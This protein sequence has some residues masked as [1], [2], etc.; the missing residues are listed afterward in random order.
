M[1]W[2]CDGNTMGMRWECDGNSHK[3]HS[4]PLSEGAT[5]T[6][7]RKR[8]SNFVVLSSF[9]KKN[10][11]NSGKSC[12]FAGDITLIQW[13]YYINTIMIA[14]SSE[15]SYAKIGR[16]CWFVAMWI[17]LAMALPMHAQTTYT[18]QNSLGKSR[19]PL[20]DAPYGPYKMQAVH[21]DRVVIYRKP[22]R[23]PFMLWR[24]DQAF[25]MYTRW[26]DYSTNETLSGLG[27]YNSGQQAQSGLVQT[28]NNGVIWYEPNKYGSQYQ[29]DAMYT[30]NPGPKDNQVVY[31][32]CDQSSYTDWVVDN[33][34]NTFTEPTL[35]Q[36][37]VFEI[38]PA[39][40]MADKVDACSGD[41]WLE[42]Y[43]IM[44][45]TNQRVYLGPKY[46]FQSSERAYPGYFYTD[47]KGNIQELGNKSFSTSTGSSSIGDWRKTS[48][49]ENRSTRYICDSSYTVN[50][51]TWTPKADDFK[52][53]TSSTSQ[54]ITGNVNIG[55]L[56]WNFSRR[57]YISPYIQQ[58]QSTFTDPI[59]D[60]QNGNDLL[61]GDPGDNSNWWGGWHAETLE[62][63]A[64]FPGVID[65]VYITCYAK[66]GS[67]TGTNTHTLKVNNGVTIWDPVAQTNGSE[68]LL[69]NTA[70]TYYNK[71]NSI[72]SN[73]LTITFTAK[74]LDCGFYIQS[75]QVHYKDTHTKG[76][77]IT[78]DPNPLDAQFWTKEE[79]VT[80]EAN[81]E[82]T[83]KLT[84]GGAGWMWFNNG[85]QV[86]EPSVSSGQFI[87]ADSVSS[88]S[89]KT[90]QL[91]YST[92][93]KTITTT[94][95]KEETTTT[96]T[97]FRYNGGNWEEVDTPHV[98]SV[99]T[100]ESTPTTN[101]SGT[102][103][104]YKIAQFRVKYLNKDIV[105]P[106]S[107]KMN[108]FISKMELLVEQDFNFEYGE[109]NQFPDD[110]TRYY[111]TPLPIEQSNYGFYYGSSSNTDRSTNNSSFRNCYYNEYQFVN[112][113][114]GW[115]T[116][117]HLANHVGNDT[118]YNKRT[119]FALYTDGSQKPGTVFSIDF[120]AD[121]CPGAKMYFSAW[122]GDQNEGSYSAG[123]PIFNFYVEGIDA[124]GNSHTLATFTTGEFLKAEN[125]WHYILFPLEFSEETI[126]EKYRFRIENMAATTLNND[127]FLDDV[128]VYLQRAS[129]TP[130]QASVTSDASCLNKEGTM[131]LCTRVD[132]GSGLVELEQN[133]NQYSFYYRWY[134]KNGNPVDCNYLNKASIN[135]LPYGKVSFPM[136]ITTI[137][138]NDTVISF[139]RFDKVASASTNPLFKF[140]EEEFLN[141]DDDDLST[142]K[143]YVLYVATPIDV[144]LG[145]FYR[146]IVANSVS[147]LPIRPDII[148]GLEK[149]SSDAIVQ[150]IHGLCIRCER[151]GGLVVD[152]AQ[153]NANIS[154][155][156]SLVSETISHNEGISNKNV[157]C[158][159]GY[160]LFGRDTLPGEYDAK[161]KIN[162][163]ETLYGATY[164]EVEKAII[165]YIQNVTFDDNDPN[166]S[167]SAEQKALVERLSSIGVLKLS[168]KSLVSDTSF[169]VLPLYT[170]D[171]I[172][173]SVFP[174]CNLGGSITKCH[175]PL[176]ISL[177]FQQQS[178][179]EGGGGGT[180]F[181]RNAIN[182]VKKSNE[183]LPKF[184][185]N[186][187]ARRV[188]IS[189]GS[190]DKLVQIE[191][192]DNHSRYT[193]EQAVMIETTNTNL[194]STILNRSNWV[195]KPNSVITGDGIKQ[196]K[197]ITLNDLDPGYNYTFRMDYKISDGD[198][199]Y[200]GEAFIT[201]L[202][203]PEVVYY[204]GTYTDAW[205][206]DS[207]WQR[208]IGN[209]N[210]VAALA[211]LHNTKVVVKGDGFKLVVKPTTALDSAVQEQAVEANAQPYITYDI[212]YEPFV[213]SEVFLYGGFHAVLGQHYLHTYNENGDTIPPKWTFE[214]WPP[215]KDKW[216]LCSMPIK[217]VVFGDLF[218]PAGREDGDDV[219]AVR[220][221][222][223]T[224][225]TAAI[226]RTTLRFYNSLYN[227]E[228]KQYLGNGA[229]RDITTST[230]TYGT[231]ILD[232]VIRAGFGWALGKTYDA[233]SNQD[234]L[235]RLPKKDAVYHYYQDGIWVDE[236]V[237]INRSEELG[238][239]MYEL[240]KDGKMVIRL[241]NKTPSKVF[242]FGNPTFASIDME[243][244]KAGNSHIKGFIRYTLN[245]DTRFLLAS[246]GSSD[247]WYSNIISMLTSNGVIP[248]E[249]A[250]FIVL[251]ED[252]TTVDVTIDP[253][254]L[255]NSNTTENNQW[256][257]GYGEPWVANSS[258]GMPAS[259]ETAV[260]PS[261][262]YITA[263]VGDFASATSII[264]A[265]DADLELFMLD[266][267][268]TP[269]A[270]YTVGD[271]KA[272]AINHLHDGQ[273]RIPLAMYAEEAVTQPL[274]T[275]D[276]EP[277]D[278]AEWDLVDTQTGIRQPLYR[279]LTMHLNMPQ[280][281][282]VRYYL[283]R[284]RHG[285]YTSES[286]S[287]AF[288]TYA[289]G[290]MLTIYSS[291][292]LY[293]LCVYDPAGRLLYQSAD[294]GTSC[295]V[296]L[297]AGTYIVRASGSTLKVIV[298]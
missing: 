21:E 240:D 112:D 258:S 232:T 19:R 43:D 26:Y 162:E 68:L 252:A 71:E 130:I 117:N 135:G 99:I 263:T 66:K 266:R 249:E 188:R 213:C 120:G 210:F 185:H 197:F 155:E 84:S 159:Y 94:Y 278:I 216:K 248:T 166:T 18:Y 295:T 184:M 9:F 292:T 224:P 291:D 212:G 294:A 177:Y 168:N 271:G 89:T 136:D 260:K 88:P 237:P 209:N 264:D 87:Y 236:A 203:V 83:D 100:N 243:K 169:L 283:E 81:Y 201:F 5:V 174:L 44:A 1:R 289:F 48:S 25:L 226:D 23:N 38:H 65:S 290:G 219:F 91:V 69:S 33:N 160:W 257:N 165:A 286:K 198:T 244:M 30:Y 234:T 187:Q 52:N 146:C 137:T 279:G 85:T 293:D 56:I 29:A 13:Q 110:N 113:G 116:N 142:E 79:T 255:R 194:N 158:Y 128:R 6:I 3:V 12:N 90:Y 148:T 150:V 239:P 163:L 93:S 17:V 32:G 179:P 173:Y 126:Y 164:Q 229:Y 107:K 218:I 207:M 131:M 74:T 228:T 108:D 288:Q 253:S 156:L 227:H 42:E 172:H 204:N 206:D 144:E 115:K 22:S 175:S 20:V 217:G 49:T 35:S 63:N 270:I 105:G 274:F 285:I 152:E 34:S 97:K 41:K 214:F 275:F 284:S 123:R 265:P 215:D 235:M 202:V 134:D 51:Y 8:R 92:G 191:T 220:S 109:T 133:N 280:D 96:T 67:N 268:K 103:K 2:E 189:E 138:E 190:T 182:F 143:R 31:I 140:V 176:T 59:E 39:S 256:Y 208:K 78:V 28:N 170:S 153:A 277:R 282:S 58:F 27:V 125:N 45:P 24:N 222:D 16:W 62:L 77:T 70:R 157:S 154:Y 241:T 251:N 298:P 76:D 193:I 86:T 139:N 230:W 61:F 147:A 64:T 10:L 40:E 47:G 82:K 50:H 7:L 98:S 14:K 211:P 287:D 73:S 225:G 46:A 80:E 54:K 238:R 231:N 205:N 242:L 129:I 95:T 37:M 151:L 101:S 195:E 186:L 192:T 250:A 72:N 149:C 246:G 132:Y 269:F 121:L 267:N 223:Q 261:A 276:G 199:T 55:G 15:R 53:V 167:C 245:K 106:V 127:F 247:S 122:I 57:V 272:M 36:R 297:T 118:T 145:Q 124:K 233:I 273:S 111:T 171:T 104:I 102:N 200:N 183:K 119:G 75:I 181:V 281:G 161:R 114:F 196:V 296:N 11:R 4:Y 221:I 259:P 178:K 254:M 180:D 60:P 262:I 141:P